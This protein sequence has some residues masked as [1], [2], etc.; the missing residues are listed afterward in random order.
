MLIVNLKAASQDG[1][2]ETLSREPSHEPSHE[3]GPGPSVNIGSHRKGLFSIHTETQEA[4]TTI[5]DHEAHAPFRTSTAVG[6]GDDGSEVVADAEVD[7]AKSLGGRQRGSSA[8]TRSISESSV[9]D[10]DNRSKTT[11]PN[12]AVTSVPTG[13]EADNPVRSPVEVPSDNRVG[14]EQSSN[15]E[16][17]IEEHSPS[18]V[19]LPSA[20][21]DHGTEEDS[22][23]YSRYAQTLY[24]LDSTSSE[25]EVQPPT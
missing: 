7:V 20:E 16:A 17:S 11:H 23:L 24:S 8:A 14:A 25:R 9:F 6:L 2:S 12:T 22:C 18:S 13:R 3:P 5:P 21:M 19:I 4:K 15:A 1:I 10:Q